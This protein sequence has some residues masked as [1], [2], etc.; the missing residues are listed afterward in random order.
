[1]PTKTPNIP[2]APLS[3]VSTSLDLTLPDLGTHR[4]EVQ[5]TGRIPY[6]LRPCKKKKEEEEEEAEAEAVKE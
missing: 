6:R 2:G 4:V 1:M 3:D 5:T